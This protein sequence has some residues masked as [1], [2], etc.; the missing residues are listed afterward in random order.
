MGLNSAFKGLSTTLNKEEPYNL[1]SSLS[2]AVLVTLRRVRHKDSNGRE[3]L[4]T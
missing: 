2:S 4:D 1:Y 3:K